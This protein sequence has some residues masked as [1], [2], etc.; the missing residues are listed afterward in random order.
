MWRGG[1][2]LGAALLNRRADAL[3]VDQFIE[4]REDLLA[5]L[6]QA[7]EGLAELGLLPLPLEPF[8]D[9]LFG[10]VDVTAQGVGRMAA[11]KQP[12]EQRRF[13]VGSGGIE[14]VPAL[15]RPVLIECGHG[16]KKPV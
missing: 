7:H 8:L 14:V 9:D 1:E 3:A 11:Q 5:V 16:L 6:V 10:N 12:V 2:D 13:L 4:D 15:E